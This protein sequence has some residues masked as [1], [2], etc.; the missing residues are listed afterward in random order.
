VQYTDAYPGASAITWDAT[1]DMATVTIGGVTDTFTG[2]G[3]IVFDINGTPKTVWLVGDS[4]TGAENTSIAAL[5][6]G[7]PANGEATSGDVVLVDEGTYT[8]DFTVGVG[9]TILG[10]N[11]GTAGTGHTQGAGSL[12][13]GSVTVAAAAGQSVM[14]DGLEFQNNSDNSTPFNSL[15]VTGGTDLE[16]V[17]SLFWSAGPNADTA[18]SDF[19]IFLQTGATGNIDIANNYF[20]GAS[21]AGFSTAS[22]RSGVWS[23]GNAATLDITGNTF[24]YNRTGLNL[25]SYDDATTTVTGNTFQSSGSG[26]SIGVGS[27]SNITGIT[28]NSFQDVGTDFNLQNLAT[29]TTF[30]ANATGNTASGALDGFMSILSGTGSDTITGTSGADV[31]TSNGADVGN[32]TFKGL[33]GDDAI[34]GAGETLNALATPHE[35]DTAVYDEEIIVDSLTPEV[36]ANGSGGWTVTSNTEGTD[37]L[38]DIEI[39][40]HGGAGRILLVGN[41]GYGSIVAALAEAEAGDTILLAP[42]TYNETFT[43]SEGINLLGAN[44][45]LA[46]DDVS[47]TGPES[48]ITGTITVDMATASTESVRIDGIQ[49]TDAAGTSGPGGIVFN[50]ANGHVVANSIFVSEVVGSLTLNRAITTTLNVA[51]EA[52]VVDPMITVTESSFEGSSGGT[53]FRGIEMRLGTG[54]GTDITDN[55]LTDAGQGV[56]AAISV[57][58]YQD[59][60]NDISGNSITNAATGIFIN[61]VIV[62]PIAPI[63]DVT[64]NTFTNVPTDLSVTSAGG[65]VDVEVGTN[66]ATD[67]FT[68]VVGT[69]DDEATGTIGPDTLIGGAGNDTLIGGA[70]SD[71]F[72]GGLGDDT[73]FA[74]D[75]GSPTGTGDADIDTF[76]YE[77]G[78]DTGTDAIYNF[79]VGAGGDILQLEGYGFTSLAD[80]TFNDTTAGNLGAAASDMVIVFADGDQIRL[81]DVDSGTFTNDNLDLL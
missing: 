35:G 61:S 63:N 37:T 78:V 32:D 48:I 27:D 81:V 31:L 79:Q 17:N 53:W 74:G 1:T 15:V 71:F 25:D 2:I 73:L 20:T 24:E 23:D 16:V 14:F 43:I 76:R 50:D 59:G 34:V 7:N 69:G 13:A 29:D 42:G 28:G 47:R 21:A 33:A 30:D 77:N 4:L 5:F 72:V 6:D 56:G 26:I 12:I 55:E 62:S 65:N 64:G 11:A 45:G 54:V 67:V 10:A 68:L 8:G 41:G 3:K 80:I 19:G 60:E 58:G 75:F 46:H 18:N 22:W 49:L 52:G 38:T 40:Q 70:G 44:H 51:G 36:A 9:V 57:S 39:I 66:S